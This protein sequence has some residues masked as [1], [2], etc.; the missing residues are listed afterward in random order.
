MSDQVSLKEF[1]NSIRQQILKTRRAIS[2]DEAFKAGLKVTETLR[3]EAFFK[4]DQRLVVG[5]Y[6]SLFGELSTKPINDYLM[7]QHYLALPYMNIHERG[8]MDFYSYNKGEPLIENRYHILEPVNNIENLISPDKFDALIVPLVAFDKKGN[9][10]GMGGGYY[11]RTLKKVSATCKIIGVAYDFQKV[12]K[13]PVESWD[14][15][16][17]EVITPTRSFIFS[18]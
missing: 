3:Q 18:E 5:S 8:L 11:D 16:L 1:R 7:E 15:P 17:D 10:M 14:M 4:Q 13:L 12:D 2:E 6:L 9:R